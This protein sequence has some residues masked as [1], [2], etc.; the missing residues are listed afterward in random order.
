MATGEGYQDP[1]NWHN[2]HTPM[3]LF[4]NIYAAFGGK[5]SAELGPGEFV[6]GQSSEE[7]LKFDDQG[8]EIKSQRPVKINTVSPKDILFN[9]E[10]TFY[11]PVI[12]FDT[13][14]S[15]SLETEQSTLIIQGRDAY[16]TASLGQTAGAKVGS[17]GDI[18][19]QTLDGTSCGK[20]G[21][22]GGDAG[23]II[24]K[25]GMA[26]H[27]HSPGIDGKHGAAIFKT[28]VAFGKNDDW[29]FTS[30][31][32][33]PYDMNFSG[34][35][36]FTIGL[37]DPRTTVVGNQPGPDLKII[38]ADGI[39]S[40]IGGS[41]MI[42]GGE[43]GTDGYVLINAN[44]SSGN[45]GVGKMIPTYKLEVEGTFGVSGNSEFG[46]GYGS[47]GVDISSAGVI[48]ADGDI[49]SDGNVVA[50]YS[51][52]IRLKENLIIIDNAIDKINQLSGYTFKW[53]D[54]EDRPEEL[55]NER[56]AGIIAQDVVK[57]LPEAVKERSDGY[58]AIKYE[59][60]IPLLI[61]GVKGQQ[62]QI[63]DLQ[64]QIKEIKNGN[65]I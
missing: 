43:G 58:L 45:V 15:G 28:Q 22:S 42:D 13:P 63:E 39:G 4:D 27:G 62:K 47:T 51:S 41:I 36:D 56:E 44:T 40:G 52:D 3:I 8:L 32:D 65:P 49:R 24:F 11:N 34:D 7:F 46:G 59:Q 55:Y 1:T 30:G 18:L 54:T 6:V 50:Y 10:D 14:S 23:R 38:G 29:G 53:K 61:E 20:G 26:G 17:S 21:L 19:I 33:L 25:T 60:M 31:S 16:F 48:S 2:I 35:S 64:Q 9:V 5:K 57:V 37:T 12:G